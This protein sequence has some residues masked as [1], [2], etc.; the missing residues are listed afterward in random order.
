MEALSINNTAETFQITLDKKFFDENF[1]RETIEYLRTEYLA[2]KLDFADSIEE[3]GEEIKHSWWQKNK[4]LYIK[5][6]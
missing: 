5:S 4:A 1:L 3:I 6:E 2:Q